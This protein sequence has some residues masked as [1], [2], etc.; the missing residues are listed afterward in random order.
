MPRSL[1]GGDELVEVVD[2]AQLRVHRVVAALVAADRPR[3]PD[4]TRARPSRCCCGP[5][6]APCRSGESAAG[7]PRRSPSSRCAAGALAAVAKVP[8]T[9]LP[10]ASQPPVDRGNS[11]Y[12]EP[13]RAS[14]RSTHTP[15]CSPRVTSSR[16]GYCVSS[17]SISGANA[18]PA[19]VE[20][21]A[22]RRAARRRPS[23]S[24]ARPARG[25]PVAARSSSC[26]PTSR[27]LDNSASL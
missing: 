25:T 24:G 3:R 10:L 2:G 9:G 18:A 14:G 23:I 7:R 16:S 12:Q 13:K 19:R 11:S 15:Y 27:S 6:G 20:R 1:G 5:C 4:V 21:V 26:A 22:G 17:S 8:C